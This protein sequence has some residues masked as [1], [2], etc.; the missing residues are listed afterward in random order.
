MCKGC[1]NLTTVVFGE[2]T[3][4]V[5]EYAFVDCPKIDSLTLH[6]NIT[7]IGRSAFLRAYALS[8]VSIPKSLVSLGAYAFSASGVSGTIVLPET[9]TTV[10]ENVFNGCSSLQKAIIKCN[11]ISSKMF[12]N[13]SK[14]STLVLTKDITSIGTDSLSGVANGN[15]LTIYTGNDPER[16]KTLNGISRFNTKYIYSYEQ[17]LLD[18]E[19]GVTYNQ[20]TIICI[21]VY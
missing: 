3:R 19:N 7:T 5:D 10:G 13:C 2:N 9:L 20:N 1:D 11:T 17:Y 18:I 14:L 8:S 4:I 12:I 15:F 6:D 16:L 21:C